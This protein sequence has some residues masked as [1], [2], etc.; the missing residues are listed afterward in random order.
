MRKTIEMIVVGLALC[1]CV[2]NVV[3]RPSGAKWVNVFDK[4]N[5]V[6]AA[7]DS[8]TGAVHFYGSPE[9]AF[10]ALFASYM[11]FVGTVNA[12]RQ[13]K[14]EKKEAK[15]VGKQKDDGH[16]SASKVH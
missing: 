9:R 10:D 2:S 4:D 6:V 12:E 5:E 1:G 7:V 14:E 13:K 3:Q 16:G 15:R 8:T 11:Q